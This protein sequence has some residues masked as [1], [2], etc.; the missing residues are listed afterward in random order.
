MISDIISNDTKRSSIE[1]LA[2]VETGKGAACHTQGQV[3]M[4]YHLLTRFRNAVAALSKCPCDTDHTANHIAVIRAT[5]H[6]LRGPDLVHQLHHIDSLVARFRVVRHLPVSHR[7]HILQSAVLAAPSS[8]SSTTRRGAA[9]KKK[10]ATATKTN[11][12]T[13]KVLAAQLTS[14]TLHWGC[15]DADGTVTT[16]TTISNET[17]ISLSL[18]HDP[19]L[20]ALQ[21]D[22]STLLNTTSTQAEHVLVRQLNDYLRAATLAL[23][24][25]HGTVRLIAVDESLDGV[26]ETVR[27]QWAIVRSA[28]VKLCPLLAMA[29]SLYLDVEVAQAETLLHQCSLFHRSLRGRGVDVP[30]VTTPLGTTMR[31]NVGRSAAGAIVFTGAQEQQDDDNAAGDD[32]EWEEPVYVAHE[33]HDDNRDDIKEEEEE[34]D[35]DGDDDEIRKVGSHVLPRSQTHQSRTAV[36]QQAENTLSRLASNGFAGLRRDAKAS[37]SHNNAVLEAIQPVMPGMEG[38][39]QKRSKDGKK[40][41]AVR[42]V[43]DR[44]RAKLGIKKPKKRAPRSP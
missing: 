12:K 17:T 3:H 23:S 40:K 2:N 31:N 27:A 39:P 14:L 41:Q 4:D 9:A 7:P 19:L 30:D 34:D 35:D 1:Y 5:A 29:R 25:V 36:Q 26:D 10:T 37:S 33:A 38:T 15:A 18:S 16:T 22:Y 21:V 44:L 11:S 24:D 43:H 8:S 6:S 20:H 13:V 42:S 28:V 32:D